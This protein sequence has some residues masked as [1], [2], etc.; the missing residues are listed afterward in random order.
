[1]AC[2]GFDDFIKR[3]DKTSFADDF[4]KQLQTLS[5]HSIGKMVVFINQ[6][7][8]IRLSYDIEEV[9][10][11]SCRTPLFFYDP[12]G[13]RVVLIASEEFFQGCFDFT[14]ESPFNAFPAVGFNAA[15]VKIKNLIA[16]ALRRRIPTN[17]K[18]AEKGLEFILEKDIVIIPEG[19]EEER[20]TEATGTEQDIVFSGC[21]KRF[22]K[23]CFINIK[24]PLSNKGFEVADAVRDFHI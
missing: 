19:G 22:Y 4:R 9:I 2:C 20:F 7:V 12:G 13:L 8:D 14:V 1:M 24:I 3:S 16:V 6:Q 17:S 21:L 18:I 23:G 11:F 5:E 15:E 10:Q